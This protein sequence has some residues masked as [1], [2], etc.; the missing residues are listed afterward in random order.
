MSLAEEYARQ[1]AWRDWEAAFA[2]CPIESG[3]RVLDL[4]CGPGDL[5][6]ELVKRGAKVIGVDSDENLLSIARKRD[7]KDCTFLNQD[8]TMLQLEHSSFDG[9]WCS[10]TAAYFTKFKSVVHGWMPLLKPNAWICVTEIDDLLGHEPMPNRFRVKLDE[11]YADALARGR[12]DFRSGHKVSAIL[13]GEG[14]KVH[15]RYLRDQELAFEG[16]ADPAVLQAWSDRFD[17][18]S[19]FKNFLGAEFEEFKASFLATIASKGHRSKCRVFCAVGN[20]L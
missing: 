11:F 1:F 13:K 8:L 18:M 5:S 3:Q 14:F 6:S 4:G 12:Y 15:E 17:R 9:I 19:G 20:R 2:A 7:L 10:F 16:S